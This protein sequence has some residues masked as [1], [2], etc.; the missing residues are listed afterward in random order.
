MNRLMR[1]LA[2]TA[3]LLAGLIG[4]WA[5]IFFGYVAY[6]ELFHVF[7]REGAYAMGVAF[8]LRRRAL[9]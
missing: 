1:L 6:A 2:V 4:G 5:V 3:A 8:G 9:S 7:D